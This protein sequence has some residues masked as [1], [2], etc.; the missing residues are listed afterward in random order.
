MDYQIEADWHLLNT[1]NYRCDYCFFS[2]EFL[3]SKLPSFAKAEEWG[4]AFDASGLVWLVHLTG[5]EPSVYPDFHRLCVALT[6]RHFISV[7]SNMTNRVW[8]D[9]AHQVNPIRV[10]FINAALHLEE[11][12]RRAGNASYLDQVAML[13]DRGFQVF[14]SLVGSPRALARF[15][16]AIE[17]LDSIGMFPA[18]KVMRGVFEGKRYP[19]AYTDLDKERFRK[20]AEMARKFYAPTLSRRTE[21]PT[22]DM[23]RDDDIIDGEPSYKGLSCEAGRLFVRIDPKGELFRCGT[24]ESMGNIREGTFVRSDSPSPC[25]TSYCFYFCQKYT[26]SRPARVAL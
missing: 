20:Y 22:L 13:L 11:R 8:R 24:S 14:C 9:F 16:D 4:A 17:L 7:N 23:F 15:E 5:G 6:R 18:P 3:S 26:S 12:E 19:D 2:D 25:D 21:R 10:S 1:C